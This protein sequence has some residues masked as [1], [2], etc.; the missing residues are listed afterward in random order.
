MVEGE[1]ISGKTMA[2]GTLIVRG[3]MVVGDGWV[4]GYLLQ[5]WR[6]LYEQNDRYL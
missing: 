5:Q 2:A 1:P 6:P 3:W 4:D